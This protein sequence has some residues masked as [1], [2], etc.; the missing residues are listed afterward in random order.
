MTPKPIPSPDKSST[1]RR[2]V[3]LRG[4]RN[5][6]S[7]LFCGLLAA[8][9]TACAQTPLCAEL[10]ACGGPVPVGDWLLG[11]GHPS[12]SEDLYI[13]PPDTRLDKGDQPAAR[14]PPAEAALYDWCDLLVTNGGEKVA[15]IEPRFSFENSTIGAAFLRYGPIDASGSGTYAAGLT[16]TGTYTIQ[17]PPLCIRAFGAT[18][19]VCNKLQT[20]LG[21]TSA[22]KDILCLADPEDLEGCICRFNVAVQ[23]GGS[24]KYHL[25]SSNTLV[26]ELNVKF[27]LKSVAAAF[28][29]EATYCNKGSSLQLTGA[30]GVY[31]FDEPGLRTMDLASATINCTDGVQ[32]PAEE[33]VD[34]GLACPT[35]C[36]APAPA[37][38][39]TM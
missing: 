34:C 20:Q 18:G 12:C 23:S 27:P 14:T 33:G 21:S 37:M 19:D 2:H 28:P 25:L 9:A 4:G 31:L 39:A 30:D 6:A 13:P 3:A 7:V 36:M 32:G 26:H 11:G 15:T 17:F 35:A 16:R 38:P 5:G 1:G 10:D 29:Q 22:H 8:F 24:G